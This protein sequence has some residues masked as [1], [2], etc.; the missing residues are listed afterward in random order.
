MAVEPSDDMPTAEPKARASSGGVRGTAWDHPLAVFVYIPAQLVLLSP[1]MAVEPSDDMPTAVPKASE[2]YG[3]V[4][5][6]A[7]DHISVFVYIPAA[8]YFTGPI[9]SE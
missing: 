3:G 8:R 6:T 9:S 1:T 2:P 4:R 5:G 7:W